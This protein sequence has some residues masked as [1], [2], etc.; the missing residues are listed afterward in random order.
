MTWAISYFIYAAFALYAGAGMIS[1]VAPKRNTLA[2]CVIMAGAACGLAAAIFASWA[3]AHGA[4]EITMAAGLARLN[5]VSVFFLYIVSTGALLTAAFAIGYL[6]RYADVFPLREV[7]TASALFIAGMTAV[8]LANGPAVF[9]IAWEVMSIS[10]YFLVIADKSEE[11]FHAGFLYFIVTQ[12]GFFFLLAGF[13][14]LAQGSL[15]GTW[16]SVVMSAAQVS[17]VVL[18]FAFFFLFTGFGSKAGLVPLHQWLPYAHPQAPSHSSALLSGVMLAVALYGFL[19]VLTLFPVLSLTWTWV[20]IAVGLVSALSGALH[21]AVETDAKRLLAWSSI[22][23]MG[24]LFAA[25]GIFLSLQG[26][27]ISPVIP[28]LANG[29][30]LFVALH[31]IN[32]FLFKAGLFMGVGAVVS[33]THTRSL[34]EMGGLARVWPFFS[35]AFLILA[36]AAAALPPFGAFFGE[37]TLVQSLAMGIGALPI[38]YAIASALIL[39]VVGLVA[40]LALFAN[41]K[42]FSMLFLGRPRTA[43]A[44][45]LAPLPRMMVIPPAICAGLSVFSGALLIPLGMLA[46]AEPKDWFAARIAPGAEM[47]GWLVFMLFVFALVFAYSVRRLGSGE[48]RI[49]PTWDCGTPLTPRMQY[50]ATGFAAPIR[51][52]FRAFLVT[53]KA[54]VTEQVS[55]GNPWIKRARLEWTVQSIW[56]R[57]VYDRVGQTLLRAAQF[58]RRLQS[59]VV[60]VYL[61]L[62]LVTLVVTIIIAI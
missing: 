61:L 24:L 28:M 16:K 7:N 31:V 18:T 27:L 38:G 12:I 40:G 34:D 58:I 22:E 25:V 49:T 56:E 43:H 4:R 42:L 21:A 60:Q 19:H 62:V 20:I 26:R 3:I 11:S 10:A 45:G 29:I 57:W 36:L 41:V 51:F 53:Q 44:E 47:N 48:V 2:Q 33:G 6:P 14:L 39:A 55:A 5:L 46:G 1:L 54:F 8:L 37:W 23:H 52:F 35:G 30:Q 17:P 9:L 50:S 13:L 15:F 32:H 59:G